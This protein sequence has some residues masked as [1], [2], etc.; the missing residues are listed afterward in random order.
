MSGD[1]R[2]AVRSQPEAWEA[3]LAKPSRM[4]SCRP[5]APLHVLMGWAE[6]VHR[7]RYNATNPQVQSR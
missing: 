7:H 4:F 1:E 3:C 5:H 2:E 6:H